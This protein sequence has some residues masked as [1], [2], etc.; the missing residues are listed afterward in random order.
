[1]NELEF[2]D[3]RETGVRIQQMKALEHEIQMNRAQRLDGLKAQL[4]AEDH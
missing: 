3:A 4:E 1:M 2:I